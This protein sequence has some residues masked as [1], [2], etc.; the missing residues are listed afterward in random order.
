MEMV[1]T[2]QGETQ[3]IMCFLGWKEAQ[4]IKEKAILA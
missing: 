2:R 4:V 1:G 3:V